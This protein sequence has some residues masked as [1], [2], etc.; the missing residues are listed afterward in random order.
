[1]T[2]C[3]WRLRFDASSPHDCLVELSQILAG[4]VI[5]KRSWRS[6]YVVVVGKACMP[7]QYL[8]FMQII[9]LR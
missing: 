9:C 8:N 4:K 7:Q 2:S 6:L 5:K 1:M 3:S